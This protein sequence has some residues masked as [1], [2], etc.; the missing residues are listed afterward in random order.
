MRIKGLILVIILFGILALSCG[1]HGI[2]ARGGDFV[3][4]VEDLRFE[5]RNLGTSYRFEDTYEARKALVEN[6]AVRFFLVQETLKLGTGTDHLQEVE[7]AV[8][9]EAVAAAYQQ[10]KIQN[11]VRLP[12]V[13]TLP[14][15][16]RL[17]RKL[18]FKEIVFPVYP[19]AEQAVALI[20]AG[21]AF[22]DVA[23]RFSG[24]Q[25]VRVNEPEWKFWKN[26]DESVAFSVFK[27]E[28]GQ[29][30]EI[31]KAGDGYHLVYLMDDQ[32][33]SLKASI[34]AARSKVF[35]RAMEEQRLLAE[36]RRSLAK[37]VE[38]EFS[39]DGLMGA[40]ESFGVSFSGGLPA[41]SL[42]TKAV[43]TYADEAVTV[44]R[45]YSYYYSLPRMVRPYV[46][47]YHAIEDLAF[48]IVL[49]ELRARAGYAM[50]LDRLREVR[51]KVRTARESV[52]VPQ[53]EEYFRGKVV[54]T[55]DDLVDYYAE[56]K[57]DLISQPRYRARRILLR[58]EDEAQDVLDEIASG[59]DFAEIA[60]ERSY[61]KATSSRGGDLGYVF[62]G[63]IAVY[64]SIILGLSPGQVSEAFT[65]T[66][67][68]E[69]LKL[70]EVSEPRR[71]SYD[72]AQ[73]YMK[74]FIRNT[75]AN[76]HLAAWFDT[77]KE[78]VGFTINEGLL[79]RIALPEPEIQWGR[80]VVP[81]SGI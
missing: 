68:I 50:G 64:D 26:L 77:R 14:W 42:L 39:E 43:A 6:I 65:S 54:V 70:E 57:D 60:R 22:D 4:T 32:P 74:T 75:R 46:G 11:S 80:T 51:W 30:S 73:P 20:E 59:K 38:L 56:R 5:V 79:R 18:Y 48:E 23:A 76:E 3:L 19:G 10:W 37:M 16:Q 63:I 53:M 55:E 62:F 17:N 24:S 67:G 61:D 1:D 28:P 34:L 66:E 31:I 7:Q 29:A 9:A 44:D 36:E 33:V 15:V 45:L 78:E 2:I 69:V 58:T 21:M 49:P 12:R 71:L 8:E 52:L 41:D 27:L 25:G 72:E 40:L 47:D 13:K 35:V 81:S